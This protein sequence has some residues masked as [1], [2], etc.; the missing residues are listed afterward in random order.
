MIE[1][2]NSIQPGIRLL[3]VIVSLALLTSR[4][5]LQHQLRLEPVAE[6]VTGFDLSDHN[7]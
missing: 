5:P 2:L 3:A 6:Q 7:S 4:D 1:W